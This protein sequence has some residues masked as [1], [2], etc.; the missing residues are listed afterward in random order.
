MR[1]LYCVVF[2][3][4]L[5]CIHSDNTTCRSNSRPGECCLNFHKRDDGSCEECPLGTHGVN[6]SSECPPGYYGL[7]CLEKCNCSK[8]KCN[9]VEGCR[10]YSYVASDQPSSTLGTNC[11][12]EFEEKP[13]Q[14]GCKCL[15]GNCEL[16]VLQGCQ[17]ITTAKHLIGGTGT[18]HNVNESGGKSVWKDVTHILIGSICTI[19][20]LV[21]LFCLKSRL[22]RAGNKRDTGNTDLPGE[23]KYQRCGRLLKEYISKAVIQHREP[24]I[25]N[26]YIQRTETVDEESQYADLRSSR[27]I[28]FHAEVSVSE[29]RFLPHSDEP[30]NGQGNVSMP[31][32]HDETEE[33]TVNRN[34]EENEYGHFSESCQYSVLSLRRNMEPHY[35]TDSNNCSKENTLSHEL[36]NPVD[37]YYSI[38]IRPCH[39]DGSLKENDSDS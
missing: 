29:D 38:S 22:K 35:P 36:E 11:S 16:R 37:P 33:W 31:Q 15:S 23:R 3:V 6:C 9:S 13:C 7:F 12:V 19:A 26:A 10:D 14:A 1:I 4:T 20:V 18:R 8:D 28:E 39:S 24:M 32:L 25:G 5:T 34:K 17:E 27:M 2:S 30:R 21:G